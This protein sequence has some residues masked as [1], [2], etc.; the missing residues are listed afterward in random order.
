MEYGDEVIVPAF[1]WVATANVVESIGAKPVFC[2]IQVDTFNIDVSK[3]ESLITSKT[4]AI[5]PVHLF[6]LPVDIQP[7][8]T[9]SIKYNI[10][11]I[12]DAA[13][14]FAARLNGIHVGNFGN[15]G[16]FSF[17][18]RKAITTGE[19]G[20]ITTNN[21]ELAFKLK[22]MRDHGATISDHQR[23]H[24]SKPYLFP[25]FPFLGFNYR[26]T[27]IQAS[28][29]SSQLD[30]ADEIVNRRREIA[31]IYTEALQDVKWLKTPLVSNHSQHGFQAYVC[32]FQP[33]EIT[34]NNIES[35]RN[36]RNKFMDYLQNNGIS[37]RPGTH[38]VHLLNYYREKYKTHPTDFWGAY[39]ADHCSIALPIFP[40]LTLDEQSYII[41]KIR[42]YK[43]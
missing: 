34:K 21:E 17:H 26:M 33:E 4:K 8:I 27:D 7:L 1:T 9:L 42:S 15:T 25:D 32:L 35:I 18:P 28:I 3:I 11:I 19:G 39:V 22:A 40:A 16:C 31:E 29:G 5:I 2:D 41:Q 30:K 37:T 6:G 12:E 38:A 20:M 43:S 14:G 10:F 24:G 36:E 13:C 23:H